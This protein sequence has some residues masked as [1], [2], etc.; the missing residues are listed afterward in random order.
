MVLTSQVRERSNFRVV[1]TKFTPIFEWHFNYELEIGQLGHHVIHLT[2]QI[3]DNGC[4][5]DFAKKNQTKNGP[6]SHKLDKYLV[7]KW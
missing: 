3:P 4:I 2:I 1:F 5:F 7:F 6:L